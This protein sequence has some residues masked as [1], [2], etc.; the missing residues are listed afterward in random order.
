MTINFNYLA[1]YILWFRS[2]LFWSDLII[3]N[4]SPLDFRIV[5]D[6]CSWCLRSAQLVF[7]W[8]MHRFN[9]S[10]I[11][12]QFISRPHLSQ[13]ETNEPA[14]S[15]IDSNKSK[16]LDCDLNLLNQ[17]TSSWIV[18][19]SKPAIWSDT[20]RICTQARYTK[21]MGAMLCEIYDVAAHKCLSNDSDSN[22]GGW[23]ILCKYSARSESN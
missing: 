20:I 19:F 1:C 17:L 18:N 11:S 3:K 10:A 14:L 13:A 2:I 23:R 15:A 9:H 6:F 4:R 21:A 22:S 7:V 12:Q 5:G 8:S 16:M